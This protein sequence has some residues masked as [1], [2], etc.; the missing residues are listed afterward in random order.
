MT[1]LDP[2]L[3]QPDVCPICKG[4]GWLRHNVPRGHALFGRATECECLEAERARRL[5]DEMRRLSALEAFQHLAFDNFDGKVAGVA[6]AFEEARRFAHDASD[7]RWLVLSGVPGSGKTHIAAAIANEAMRRGRAVLFTV[8]PDLLDHLR[9]TFAPA[10]PVQYDEMFEGVRT[11]EILILDDL[12]TESATPWA[13]E[14]LFQIINYRYNFRYPTVFTT[15]RRFDSLDERIRS[16]LSDQVLCKIFEIRAT[17]YRA[18]KPGQR[19]QLAPR[20]G[21]SSEQ[22]R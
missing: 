17:D 7:W 3:S 1:D 18:L 11:T 22:L 19:R 10:S 15:N 14:K 5:A 16:R 9:S 21:S 12:G 20:R 4:A 6:D 8:V 2:S 13:Q